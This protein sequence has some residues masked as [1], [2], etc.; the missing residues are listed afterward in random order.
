M[1]IPTTS[2]KN[3]VAVNLYEV[4]ELRIIAITHK[5]F[6]LE[7]IGKLHLADDTRLEALTSM[8]STN[9]LSELM[10]LATCNRVEIIFSL[11]HYVCPGVTANMLRSL[12]PSLNE[13][14][15]R[16]LSHGAERYNGPEAAEHLLKVASG[17]ESLVIGEREI[18]TQLRKAYEECSNANLTGDDLR[19]LVSQ[20]IKT[21]K[22]I[23][24]TTDLA[25][26]PV[27]VVSLAWQQFREYGVKEDARILLIGAGQIIRNFT[28][29][30]S[31]NGYH[32]ITIANRSIERAV[33]LAATCQGNAITLQE[34]PHYTSGFD[35]L[36]SCTASND[37]VITPALYT[38]LLQGDNNQKL[39][40][41][42]ALPQDI[43][44]EIV[45]NF[46]VRY[47]DM[48]KIQKIASENIRFREQAL[49]DCKPIIEAS[50]RDF[51]KIWQARQVERAMQSIPETI[52]DI[53]AT[54]LGSV[55]AKDLENLDEE[56]RE[57]LE[58]IMNYMEKKYI[59]IPMKL[60]KEVLL[61]EITRN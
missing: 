49:E 48:L 41:D 35:V 34:L 21:S 2:R 42:L 44:H 38:H 37:A 24:T 8:K 27:S 29:F 13:E 12:Y 39:L 20:C 46:P 7:T 57:L 55:F 22:E 16:S 59:S 5:S 40:I 18:I 60:A 52:R 1:T 23:F 33:E 28:K 45:S 11:P 32:N 25:K 50:M 53:K 9:Q 15:I 54:A 17:T 3:F 36:V 47:I 30:L 4:N 26:K 61:S 56:A 14:E 43:D 6:P 31:E 19:L 58:K 51:E 10:F